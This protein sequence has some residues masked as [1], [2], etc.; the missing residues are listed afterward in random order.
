MAVSYVPDVVARAYCVAPVSKP[1]W[2]YALGCGASYGAAV[3]LEAVGAAPPAGV[4]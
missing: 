2:S 3:L 4:P 1:L